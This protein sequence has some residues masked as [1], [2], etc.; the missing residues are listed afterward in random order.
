[1]GYRNLS[2]QAMVNISAPW[3]DPA[4]DR[5]VFTSLPLLAPLLP[6]VEE[7]REGWHL[8]RTAVLHPI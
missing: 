1:M 2:P 7:A 8:A 3:L 6:A 5:K 4:Q